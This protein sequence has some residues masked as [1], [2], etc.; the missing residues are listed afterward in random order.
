L[1]AVHGLHGQIQQEGK[2]MLSGFIQAQAIWDETMAETAASFLTDH[3]ATRMVILAGSQHTRNDSG[4]PPRVAS[5][6]KV[7]QASVVN[8]SG[9]HRGAD[10]NQTTDFFFVADPVDLEPVGKMGLVL[11]ELKQGEQKG[12]KIKEISPLG[13]AAQAGVQKD[14]RLIAI[15]NATI[16]SMEDVRIMLMDK[17]AGDHVTLCIQRQNK[18]QQTEEKELELELSNLEMAKPHP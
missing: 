7:K 4:I 8:L 5:R 15:N 17:Q 1:S 10:M 9:E 11:T 14:D 2:G 12:M 3:P 18:R 6:I 16:T 13:K